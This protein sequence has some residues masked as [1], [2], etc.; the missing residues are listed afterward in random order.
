MPPEREL[1]EILGVP[2]TATAEE[3]KSAYRRAARKHHPDV[4]PGDKAAEERFKEVAAA[5]D[6]LGNPEKRK[7]YDELGAD[8]QKIGFD[9]E[10][11][12]AYRQW[13]AARERTGPGVEFGGQE[14]PFDL[15]DIFGDIFGGAAGGRVWRGRAQGPQAGQDVEATL[16]VDL[17][18]SITG[19]ERR[20]ELERPGRPSH[21]KLEVKIPKGAVDGTV[22]RL[23]GQGSAGIR[24]GPPGDLLLTIQLRPHPLVRRDGRDLSFDLPVTLGEAIDG[25]EVKIPTFEGPVHLKIP[26]GSQSGRRLRLRGKGL[27]D[28]RGGTRGDLYAVVQVVVPPAGAKVRELAHELDRHY[29]GDVRRGL[30]L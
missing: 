28:L 30:S 27:P 24:G 11:A 10:K 25:A 5:F 14:I 22:V 9:P 12:K 20:L 3:I 17:A 21:A 2:R 29:E 23:A 19:A 18:D 8:A 26:A 7:L 15:G 4:N 16:V 13:R 1:Y 6:V